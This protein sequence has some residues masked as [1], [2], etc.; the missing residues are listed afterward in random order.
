MAFHRNL[1]IVLA[2][3]LR[4]DAAGNSRAWPI[5]TPNM[6]KL[7]QRGLKLVASS[8]SPVD[9]GG[10]ISLL[11][12]LHARQHGHVDES[13]ATITCDGWPGLLKAQG[14]HVAGV[15]CVNA[16]EHVLDERVVVDPV[17]VLESAH[18]NYL[19][20]SAA[21]GMRT[22]L[23]QQRRQRLRYGPFHPDRLL[24]EPDEDIDGFISVQARRMLTHMPSDKPWALIVAYSGPGNEL[25]PPTLYQD[26][27]APELLEEG[28]VPANFTELDALAELDYPR[29]MLQR[30]EPQQIARIRADYLGRVSL[31]DYGIGR[32]MSSVAEREDN[33]RTWCVVASD[34]GMLLGEHGLVGHRSFL[35]GA[36]E[37]PVIITPPFRTRCEIPD[38]L[39]SNVDVAATIATLGGC[40]LP[41]YMTGRSLLPLLAGESITLERPH[42][43]VL[44]EF[45]QRLMLE[46]ERYKIILNTETHRI[47]GL[48]DLLNDPDEKTNLL[49]TMTGR[50]VTDAL[51]W[52]LGDTLMPLRA[53]PQRF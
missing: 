36:V 15:G 48:Y 17:E 4:A 38:W 40:D 39:I 27:V 26:V 51:R 20:A 47:L 50:N 7:I 16:I 23:V 9:P 2:H 28:F 8:A 6:D 12:G 13:A 11:T 46:T 52:R 3:G 53:A 41:P 24:M 21:S 45:G 42:T 22:A 19:T 37:V 31:I 5:C 25:P 10:M 35:A 33:E 18:C 49:K 29:V 14:Y 30:L 32:M 44:S 1:L 34:R 43:G